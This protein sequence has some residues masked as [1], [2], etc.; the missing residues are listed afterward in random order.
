MNRETRHTAATKNVD[1]DNIATGPR[2]PPVMAGAV[3]A[4]LSL[5]GWACY[6]EFA[7]CHHAM[8]LIARLRP[9]LL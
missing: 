4:L 9:I 7:Y 1:T 2:L 3:W 8:T 6:A 5:V